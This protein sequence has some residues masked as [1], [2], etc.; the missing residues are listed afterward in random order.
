LQG[1]PLSPL[2]ANI[3]LHPFDASLVKKGHRL[4]RFADDWVI[5]CPT[6]ENAEQAYNAAIATLARLKLKANPEK[7]RLLSPGEPLDWLGTTIQLV[8]Q[9]GG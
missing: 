1:S 5:C 3:Y 9:A 7:T 8:P 2:L 4:A 6:Q